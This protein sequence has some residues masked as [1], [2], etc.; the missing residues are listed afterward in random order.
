M[1]RGRHGPP[2]DLRPTVR[3]RDRMLLMQTQK[4]GGTFVPEPIDEAVMESAKAGPRVEG[5]VGNV[6]SAQGIGSDIAAKTSVGCQRPDRPLPGSPGR[7]ADTLIPELIDHG[8]A[9]G[10]PHIS[11]LPE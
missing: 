6:K 3:N 1:H 11:P 4:H 9:P 8:D 5:N 7:Y 10:V 2:R